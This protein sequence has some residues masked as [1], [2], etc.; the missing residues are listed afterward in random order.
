MKPTKPLLFQIGLLAV[1]GIALMIPTPQAQGQTLEEIAAEMRSMKERISEL[2][3]KLEVTESKLAS[4]E[5]KAESAK[6]SADTAVQVASTASAGS[7]ITDE[8]GVIVNGDI[9]LPVIPQ[10]GWWNK[11]SIGGYGEMHLTL[12]DKEEIDFHRFVLFVD[13]QFDDRIRLVT[14]LELEHS[15]AGDGKPGEVEL[16][17]AYVEM[18][19][20]S[21]Y[22]AR[23]GL[24]L[25]PVGIINE[26][27]EPN[28]FFGTER[29]FVES[30]II[31]TTWWEGGVGLTKRFDNGLSL[32]LSGHSGL[33]VDADG[34]NAFRIRGGRQKVAEASAGDW[35]STLNAEYN[36]IPG[37]G[38]G[39]SIQYQ[40]DLTQTTSPESNAAWMA[41]T[42][43]D[44]QMG[45]FGLSALY[46]HWDI[47]GATPAALGLAEQSGFYIEPS[48]T[49]NTSIG[50]I[51]FFTRWSKL[52]AQKLDSN[53]YDVGMNYW[54][55][56]N[57]VLKADYTRIDEAVDQ[58]FI[59]FG[60]GF[61]F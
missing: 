2:E 21:G 20:G 23:A 6:Q 57:V 46:G 24:F 58:D 18:D 42:H 48:Y 4:A 43:I 16:E 19:L 28:T 38:I 34:S 56:E 13:H 30:E 10:E 29:N 26:Y 9:P 52:E 51:G 44:V 59:N 27:H 36:G 25:L 39:G 8:K 54:P 14:E 32:D 55:T 41:E 1:A 31:P 45:G 17:Q 5:A 53:V 15:L 61:Q 7:I 50:D 35:G 33:D 3:T 22:A 47:S 12:G 60:V 49:F 40:S 37:F 11:T